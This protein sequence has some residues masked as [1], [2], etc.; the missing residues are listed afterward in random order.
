MLATGDG[1]GTFDLRMLP[2]GVYRIDEDAGG[3][4]VATAQLY[5]SAELRNAGAWG[6]LAVKIDAGMYAAPA[7]FSINFTARQQQ[8]KYFV[9][10]S[11]FTPTEFDQLDISDKGFGDE[12]RTE[13]TFDKVPT[14][15][16]TAAD[17]AP[18]L[19]DDGTGRIVMFRSQA[20]VARRERGLRKLQLNRNGDVLVEHLP[21]PGADRAQAHLI[22]HLTKP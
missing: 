19:L 9:V 22:V 21:Q 13:V 4:S 12:S 7:A 20:P 6:I 3:G 18:S 11:N 14:A 1:A 2:E 16:F 8:L 5:V 10:A 17:I 15:S